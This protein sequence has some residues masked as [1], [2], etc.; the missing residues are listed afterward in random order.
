V[1]V[2]DNGRVLTAEGQ[3]VAVDRPG[4]RVTQTDHLSA[5]QLVAVVAVEVRA[6][7]ET[8]DVFRRAGQFG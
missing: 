6:T 8:S 1:L 4:R 3:R 5:G 7:V 2:T